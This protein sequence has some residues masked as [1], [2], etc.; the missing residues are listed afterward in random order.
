MS[1]RDLFTEGFIAKDFI[2]LMGPG[3]GGPVI[4]V[5]AKFTP[6]IAHLIAEQATRML[7]E[8]LEKTQEVVVAP[9]C[10]GIDCNR[11]RGEG[12]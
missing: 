10:R 3:Q 4:D 12:C 5:W 6:E 11:C 9:K 7:R 8:A 2:E 1:K